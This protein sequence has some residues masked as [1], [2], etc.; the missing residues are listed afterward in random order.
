MVVSKDPSEC[1]MWNGV[2]QGNSGGPQGDLLMD[3][4]CL[5]YK[6]GPKRSHCTRHEADTKPLCESVQEEELVESMLALCQGLHCSL[7]FP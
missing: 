7:N 3:V 5:G 6:K 2:E 1:C 4:G